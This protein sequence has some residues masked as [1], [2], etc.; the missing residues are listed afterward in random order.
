[1]P[2]IL[3]DNS[4]DKVK[5]LN[6]SGVALRYFRKIPSSFFL[7]DSLGDLLRPSIVLK[8]PRRSYTF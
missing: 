4:K 5:T 7:K 6:F 8:R 2:A 1:M 3:E